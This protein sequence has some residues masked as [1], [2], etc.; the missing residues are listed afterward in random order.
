LI[1]ANSSFRVG[2]PSP[3]C[4]GPRPPSP[5]LPRNRWHALPLRVVRS[6]R[7][8]PAGGPAPLSTG[9]IEVASRRTRITSVYG[10]SAV[11]T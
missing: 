11:G 6:R 8:Q 1:A 5:F 2:L 4:D 9:R 7:A 10:V 3:R